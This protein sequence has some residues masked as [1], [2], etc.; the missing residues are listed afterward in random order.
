MKKENLTTHY[1]CIASRYGIANVESFARSARRYECKLNH[2][3]E[4]VCSSEKYSELAEK[5]A[6]RVSES[7]RKNLA[8]YCRNYKQFS[9]ELFINQD[10]RGYALKLDITKP[11]S[12]FLCK[13]DRDWGNYFVLAPEPER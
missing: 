2:L 6:E 13:V 1:A 11:T 4:L 10:P 7:A 9:K 8:K 5:E 3:Y 12:H